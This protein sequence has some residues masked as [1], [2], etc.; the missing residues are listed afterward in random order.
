VTQIRHTAPTEH[1]QQA[2]RVRLKSVNNESHFHSEA[3]NLSSVSPLAL[4]WGDSNV[5]YITPCEC[6]TSTARQVEIGH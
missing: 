5:S 3:Q 1:A 2:V 6:A 4:Q